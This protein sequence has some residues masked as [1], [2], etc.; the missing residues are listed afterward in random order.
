MT[1]SETC[2]AELIIDLE[3]RYRT[4]SESVIVGDEAFQLLHPES[5]DDLIS[6]DDF[7][8]DERLPYWAAI[9]PSA[10]VLANEIVGGRIGGTPT[11]RRRAIE[12]GCGIGLVTAAMM[13]AGIDVLATDY[14]APALE[15]T[16]ANSCRNLNREATT[17]LVNWRELPNKMGRFDLLFASDV[18]YEREYAGLLPRVFDRLLEFDGRAIIADPGRVA[19]PAFIESCKLNGFRV[20]EKRTVPWEAGVIKQRIDL[21]TITR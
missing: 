2:G 6:E 21:Y 11:K 4:V 18:I 10:I 17:R 20:E 1:A 15:F 3:R 5:A 19:T 9:W 16:R 8:K 12:L 14:Y 7:A 13:K